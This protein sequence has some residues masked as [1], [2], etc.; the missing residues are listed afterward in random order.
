M[1]K[2]RK[3]PSWSGRGDAAE[4]GNGCGFSDRVQG[5]EERNAVIRG[6]IK[7]I[8]NCRERWYLLVQLSWSSYF[9]D[10]ENIYS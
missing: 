9:F 10:F 7:L 4:R 5:K 6:P 8:L 3:N 2:K 1:S